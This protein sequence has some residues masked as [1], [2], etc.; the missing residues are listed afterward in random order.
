[1]SRNTRV[2]DCTPEEVFDVL[3]DGWSYATWVVGAS[4]IRDVDA[5]WPAPGSRIHHSVGFWPLVIN[6]TSSVES[7]RR[8]H[9]I[10]L[11]VRAWP[12]GQG[13]VRIVCEPEGAHTVVTMSEDATSGPALGLLK[14]IRD[15]ILRWRNEEALRRLAYLAVGR[16][17][18][19]ARG[20][21]RASRARES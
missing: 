14:P 21:S 15:L 7:L 12:A 19:S 17:K 20:S 8:P 16:A 1:M 4:R 13:R 18:L 10:L 5:R 3:A 6:D 9:E 2:F 11:T